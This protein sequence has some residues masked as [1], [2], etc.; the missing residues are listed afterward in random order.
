MSGN[1]CLTWNNPKTKSDHK[2][3]K[4]KRVL[5]PP[6]LKI[7]NHWFVLCQYGMTYEKEKTK[8]FLWKSVLKFFDVKALWKNLKRNLA[9]YV[10]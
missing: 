8:H 4:S 5:L 7:R 2:K 6:F 1:N 3:Y 9:L 10:F